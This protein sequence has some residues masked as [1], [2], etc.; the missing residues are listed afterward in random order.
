MKELFKNLFEKFKLL[1]TSQKVECVAAFF[2][3]LFLVILIPAYAWFANSHMMETLT[4][5][6]APPALD[7]KAGNEDPIL[8]FKLSDIDLKDIVE[9]GDGT[10]CYVFCVKSGQAGAHY[11][12]QLAHT[13]NIPLEYKLY[14]ANEVAADQ[15]PD[16]DYVIEGTSNHIY[17][18][19]TSSTP[20]D[21]TVLN[22]EDEASRAIHGRY[23]AN[24]KRG[25]YS[26]EDSYYTSAYRENDRPEIYA[27]AKYS[28]T[29]AIESQTDDFEFFILELNFVGNNLDTS[30]FAKWNRSD[31][32][33]ETDIIYIS[34]SKTNL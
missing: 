24:Y 26:E 2:L 7:I 30:G 4:K 13:T 11:K 29:T 33:K 19:K 18:K 25:T 6:K 3:S 22:Q 28:Q 16:V 9:N 12:I 5:V 23:L 34:A 27:V 8:N 17:Y 14:S 10:K 31:N 32:N 21:M 1:K 20:I 15:D